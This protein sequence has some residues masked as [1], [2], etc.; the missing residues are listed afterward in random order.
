MTSGFST[1]QG[2][3]RKAASWPTDDS[4]IGPVTGRD[5]A[6]NNAMHYCDVFG[7]VRVAMVQQAGAY[8]TGANTA[9]GTWSFAFTSPSFPVQMRPDGSSY[10]L[11]VRVAGAGESAAFKVRFA[12]TVQSPDRGSLARSYPGGVLSTD[13]IWLTGDV[14]STTPAYLAGTSQGAEAWSTMIA[15]TPSE[16]APCVRSTP[17]ITDVG[18]DPIAVSQAMVQALVWTY[19]ESAAHPARLYAFELEEWPG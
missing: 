17:T 18:G 2:R 7:Q 19:V 14:N 11:R 1:Y 15:L 9:N 8:I 12:V 4:P 16:L 6:V 3:I 5:Y 13:S 10:R